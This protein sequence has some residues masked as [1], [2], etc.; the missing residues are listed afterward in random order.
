M[1]NAL[2]NKIQRKGA[3]GRHHDPLD[4]DR[5]GTEE[6]PCSVVSTERTARSRRTLFTQILNPKRLPV[7]RKPGV[8]S[9]NRD[10]NTFVWY[11][12][13]LSS[14]IKSLTSRVTISTTLRLHP[15][16]YSVGSLFVLVLRRGCWGDL[17][18][19]SS[20]TVVSGPRRQWFFN[21]EGTRNSTPTTGS[22]S[23]PSL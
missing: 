19:P 7:E 15:T 20:I 13:T 23:F 12:S 10:L 1:Y 22:T 8:H 2:G 11:T 9:P 14:Y 4:P 3:V 18:F 16:H 5:Y 6:T 17:L 21:L